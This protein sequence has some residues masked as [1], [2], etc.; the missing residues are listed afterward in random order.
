MRQHGWPAVVAAAL[1]IAVLLVATAAGFRFVQSD[2]LP[3]TATGPVIAVDFDQE[4]GWPMAE[5][6][7][8]LRLEERCLLVDDM[9]A[10]FPE[11]TTWS[12]P[13]EVVFADGTRWE[14][15]QQIVGGGDYYPTDA[16]TSRDLGG[17]VAA[18]SAS[19]CIDALGLAGPDSV[20]LVAP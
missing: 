19:S 4:D 15:G 13:D 10:M 6:P 16:V 9:L 2:P 8:T 14:V 17:E 3:A 11:G 7:G 12:E 1:M 18:A 20:V 5:V